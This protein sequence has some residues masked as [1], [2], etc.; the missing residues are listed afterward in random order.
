MYKY[1]R[2]YIYIDRYRYM[3]VCDFLVGISP[4]LIFKSWQSTCA[5]RWCQA[6]HWSCMDGWLWLVTCVGSSQG[7]AWRKRV[8]RLPNHLNQTS[9][10][11]TPTSIATSM[12]HDFHGWS[13]V[14]QKL[15]PYLI[16]FD[17]DGYPFHQSKSAP[18]LGSTIGRITGFRL[19][20]RLC[21]SLSFGLGLW[22]KTIQHSTAGR[23][24]GKWLW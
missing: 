13:I 4:Q 11:S 16:S 7:W 22:I 3:C 12:S 24:K 20:F 9:F 18:P 5:P 6:A 8:T 19:G 17:I 21:F 10:F 23:L 2:L 15:W 14:T 1:V